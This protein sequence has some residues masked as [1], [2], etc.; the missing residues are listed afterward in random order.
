MKG[1]SKR[2]GSNFPKMDATPGVPDDEIPEF[3]KEEMDRGVVSVGGVIIRGP[4]KPGR[5]LGSGK[6]QPVHIML[7]KDLVALFRKSGKG[8]QTRIN[9]ALRM[10]VEL[11]TRTFRFDELY[12]A[13]VHGRTPERLQTSKAPRTARA[14][15]A[16]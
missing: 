13:V 10:Y 4:R 7:D 3:T 2:F 16:S 14:R 1:K 5:P 15:R 8:W 12:N 11:S 6:K 9:D